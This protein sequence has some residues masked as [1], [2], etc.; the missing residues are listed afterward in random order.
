MKVIFI[1][2]LKGQG[3]KKDIKEVSDGYAMN[4]LIKNGYAVKYTKTSNEILNNEIKNE[5]ELFELNTKN[6]KIIKEKLEKET[7]TFIVK[8]G[9]N[10]KIFGS[11]STKQIIDE[12]NKLGYSNIDKRKILIDNPITSLGT[13]IVKIELFKDVIANIKIKVISK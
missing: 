13:H 9:T 8:S 3:K 7:I 5:K 4:Y 6:A 11:I 12:L 1:K 10:N 2:D